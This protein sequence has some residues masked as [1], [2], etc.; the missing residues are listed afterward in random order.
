MTPVSRIRLTMRRRPNPGILD[1]VVGPS[2]APRTPSRV[3]TSV[4]KMRNVPHAGSSTKRPVRKYRRT[5]FTTRIHQ[6][7][8]AGQSIRFAQD[9]HGEGKRHSSDPRE[10][11]SRYRMLDIHDGLL[12]R[13]L[14]ELSFFEGGTMG[15]TTS[16]GNVNI[17]KDLL[18]ILC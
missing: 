14:D 13:T 12:Y 2:K 6:H 4:R 3:A 9:V 7:S 5:H 8:Y 11:E 17:D 18:A 1:G 15:D 10:R 16:A